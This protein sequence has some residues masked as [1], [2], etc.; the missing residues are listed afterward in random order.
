MTMEKMN[1]REKYAAILLLVISLFLLAWQV[2][3]LSSA[4]TDTYRTVQGAVLLSTKDVTDNLHTF[5]LILLG[6]V[7]SIQLLR[8]KL[9]G[10][11]CSVPVLILYCLV[12]IYGLIAFSSMATFDLSFILIITGVVLLL[13]AIAFLF[14]PGTLKKYRVSKKAILPT[15]ILFMAL[16]SITFFLQ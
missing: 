9:S 7:G 11:V 3:E 10:W 4:Y 13:L 6:L 15:L 8:K 2:I 5:L 14:F 12:A 16:L 1:G